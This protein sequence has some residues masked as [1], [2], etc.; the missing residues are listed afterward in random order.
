MLE[1]N[2]KREIHKGYVDTFGCV[3]FTYEGTYQH[4]FDMYFL[5]E[6][7]LDVNRN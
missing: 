5:I 1:N 3:S 7:I 4:F 2:I 6:D